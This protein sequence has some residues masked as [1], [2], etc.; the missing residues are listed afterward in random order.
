MSKLVP[1]KWDYSKLMPLDI[2]LSGSI[3]PVESLIRLFTYGWKYM[4]DASK[5]NHGFPLTEIEEQIIGLE[6][7]KGGIR[8]VSL[9]EYNTEK[10]QVC[11]IYRWKPH[12]NEWNIANA[13][14]AK[15][16][17]LL[18][19]IFREGLNGKPPKYGY[20]TLFG[21]M[22]KRERRPV[23]ADRNQMVCTELCYTILYSFGLP[24]ELLQR[25][26]LHDPRCWDLSMPKKFEIYPP[27]P[28]EVGEYC[29][30]N[31]DYEDVQDF[32]L[33]SQ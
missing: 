10:N 9:E 2:C 27:D 20:K 23:D 15:K 11:K 22:K 31:S 16:K 8:P 3:G 5:Q 25:F 30:G 33:T 24:V 18:A 19:Y 4:G 7:A 28:K 6:M 29:A 13:T 21:F 17:A 32:K 26:G 14:I 1:F 12:Y